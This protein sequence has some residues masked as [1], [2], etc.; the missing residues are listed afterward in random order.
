MQGFTADGF[1]QEYC[2]IDA[3]SAVVLPDGMKTQDTAPIFCAGITCMS[4]R[5]PHN[6]D[7]LC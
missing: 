3:A 7:T 1:F 2:A 4:E 6:E 5:E